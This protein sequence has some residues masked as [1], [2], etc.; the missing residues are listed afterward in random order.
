MRT[1]LAEASLDTEL[2]DLELDVVVQ[3]LRKTVLTSSDADL[4]VESQTALSVL[5]PFQD[6]LLESAE[7]HGLVSDQW[8]YVLY[9][10]FNAS[11]AGTK[12]E[13]KLQRIGGS[14]EAWAVMITLL[15]TEDDEKE[16]GAGPLVVAPS[17]SWNVAF[18]L[19]LCVLHADARRP[20]R[21]I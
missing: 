6:M 19:R 3:D 2:S 20:C 5:R 21:A 7:R 1:A 13:Q 16:N 10:I 12:S 11:V 8:G 14:E 4:A 17:G 15:L 18:R 9:D